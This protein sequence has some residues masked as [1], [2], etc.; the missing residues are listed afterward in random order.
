MI[1]PYVVECS[2]EQDL[3]DSRMGVVK[4]TVRPWDR[5]RQQGRS[6]RNLEVAPVARQ[7]VKFRPRPLVRSTNVITSRRPV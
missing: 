6:R 1:D 5:Q 7:S 4:S 2:L 3:I